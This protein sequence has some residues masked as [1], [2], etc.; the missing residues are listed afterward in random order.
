MRNPDH[1]VTEKETAL[2]ADGKTIRVGDSIVHPHQ[3]RYTVKRICTVIG[4]HGITWD[5]VEVEG[6]SF[7]FDTSDVKV[8]P[9][10][11]RKR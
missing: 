7:T 6:W 9:N 2:D 11:K 8:K 3:G 1:Q 10:R 5:E 4:Y